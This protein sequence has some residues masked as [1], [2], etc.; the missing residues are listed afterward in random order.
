M[1]KDKDKK[2]TLHMSLSI[3]CCS[4]S[5]DIHLMMFFKYLVIKYMNYFSSYKNPS[6]LCFYIEVLLPRKSATSCV[7]DC[8]LIFARAFTS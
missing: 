4:Y 8:V 1:A 3:S 2:L 6:E 7:S 5:Q